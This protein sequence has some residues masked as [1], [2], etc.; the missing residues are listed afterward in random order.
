M[1]FKINNRK[2]FNL[3]K[4]AQI[5]IYLTNNLKLLPKNKTKKLLKKRWTK[6]MIYCKKEGANLFVSKKE[7]PFR[8]RLLLIVKIG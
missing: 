6:K 7:M 1:I 2:I 3:D 4:I 8:N 5:K